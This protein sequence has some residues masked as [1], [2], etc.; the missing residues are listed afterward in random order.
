MATLKEVAAAAGVAPITVS[1]VINAPETVKTE[2][3]EKVKK[4][5][6]AMHYIP[7]VAARNLVTN[8]TGIIDIFI[9]ECLDL[10][11]PF[12]M[13]LIAGISEVLSE[14]MYSFLILRNR[15]QEH[16]CDGYIVTGLLK[17]EILD[18]YHY[19]RERNRPLVLFGHTALSDVDCIDVDNVSGGK[20]A[21]EYLLR[22]GHRKIAM[23]NTD[24]K[25]DYTTDRLCGYKQALDEFKAEFCEENVIS[26]PNHIQGGMEA[27]A[28]LL[29]HGKFSA[30]FCATD[31]LA[32]G[33]AAAIRKA[34]LE[35]GRD[36]SLIGYD[37]LGY[38]LL[39]LPHITTIRQPIFQV[40]K[41]LAADLLDRLNGKTEKTSRLIQPTLLVGQS[42]R[43]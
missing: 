22:N 43:Q 13:Y 12:V 3:R 7:N 11:N 16:L 31:I 35:V 1:R 42:V 5:M 6:A 38:H 25:K 39:N 36:I 32:I 19:A 21:A 20:M 9:P 17:N 8:H 28:K 41:M 24:E 15:N 23:I 29:L 27:A 40:G 14:H 37:G 30:I 2:T 26:A 34:G 33:A 4:I 18:F 10:S